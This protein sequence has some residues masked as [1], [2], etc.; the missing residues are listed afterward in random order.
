M[1]SKCTGEHPCRSV[2]SIKLLSN[3]INVTFWH[4]CSVNLL[5]IF[6]T[7]FYKNTYGGLLLTDQKILK[8]GLWMYSRGLPTSPKALCLCYSG[9]CSLCFTNF[10]SSRPEVFCNKGVLRNFTKFTGRHLCQGLFVNKVTDRACN[11]IKKE[12][13]AQVSSCEFFEISKDTFSYRTHPVAT[14]WFFFITFNSVK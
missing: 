8:K 2:I 10:W 3:F 6:R 13:L 14:P 5:H 4:G 11:F 7:P 9:V 12:A 1:G